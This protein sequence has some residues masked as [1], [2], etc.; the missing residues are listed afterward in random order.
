MHFAENYRPGRA[1]H[2]HRNNAWALASDIT[3]TAL[4][5]VRA[6]L[7]RQPIAYYRYWEIARQIMARVSASPERPDKPQLCHNKCAAK[8]RR[9]DE[10]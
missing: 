1:K 10:L 7:V 8:R 4:S 5:A 2:K 3:G 6:S 9:L